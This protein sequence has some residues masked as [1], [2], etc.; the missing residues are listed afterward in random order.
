MKAFSKSVL[1]TVRSQFGQFIAMIGIIAL[2]VGFSAGLGATAPNMCGTIDDHFRAANAP[3]IIVRGNLSQEQLDALDA[4]P[5]ISGADGFYSDDYF[6]ETQR[7]NRNGEQVTRTEY[8][9]AYHMELQN[10]AINRL[11]LIEGIWPQNANEVVAERNNKN[12]RA[13]ALGEQLT[14]PLRGENGEALRGL[15]GAEITVS[16]T[17]VGIAANPLYFSQE[18][19]SSRFSERRT[20]E[21]GTEYTHRFALDYVYY[22][23]SAY[24]QTPLHG[25]FME[26][27]APDYTQAYLTVQGAA[28]LNIFRNGYTALINDA[29]TALQSEINSSADLTFLTLRGYEVNGTLTNG[30][31][32]VMELKAYD[33]M[34]SAISFVFPLFFGLVACLVVLSTMMRLVEKER[35]LIGCYKSL[36]YSNK[37]ILS[38]YIAFAVIACVIG[39]ALGFFAGF[40]TLPIIITNVF[41][42]MFVFPPLSNGFYYW[43]GIGTAAFMTA[44]VT[45]VTIY[46]ATKYLKER[47]AA[48]LNHKAP[49][50]GRK[51][52]LE[53]MAFL[54]KRIKF[55]WKSTLRNIF[56]YVKHLLMTVISVAGCFVLVFAAFGIFDSIQNAGWD[57]EGFVNLQT[58][59]SYVVLMLI[60]TAGALSI[61]VTYN[62]TN[63]NVEE[64]KRELATLKVLGY[65][66]GEVAGYIYREIFILTLFGVLIG[67]PLGY[68]FSDFI[69]VFMDAG[70]SLAIN[71]WSWIVSIAMT[72]IFTLI[73][74]ALLYK[75]ITG[76]DMNA[77]LKS[78]D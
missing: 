9:R 38:R 63:I 49:K 74:S 51:I 15:D 55:K 10:R 20:R 33:E 19:E 77:S 11:D 47:P 52:L 31:R 14:L 58:A 76:V 7:E 66:N 8:A 6:F 78:I 70:V 60:V 30:N 59:M 37:K 17:V 5:L 29:V 34:L 62:L 45:L 68:F 65:K 67:L 46:A 48:L 21:N 32:G 1:R 18:Q 25:T 44:V 54:W 36:G 2:G 56:R 64:R 69:L 16:A 42:I 3:D 22:F 41:K 24:L 53:R 26:M 4:H 28:A 75:K 12:M 35:A 43:F 13:V 57:G 40:R 61:I 23:D 27:F 71:W 50:P 73:T 72:F 39:S